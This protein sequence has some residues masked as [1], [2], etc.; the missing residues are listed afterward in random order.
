MATCPQRSVASSPWECLSVFVAAQAA[1]RLAAQDDLLRK[2]ERLPDLQ[3][4]WLLLA[5]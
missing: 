4:A 5:F 3:S 1:E 2:L